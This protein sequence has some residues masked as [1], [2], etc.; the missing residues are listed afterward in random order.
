MAEQ[1]PLAGNTYHE[2]TCGAD[3]VTTTKLLDEVGRI[4]FAIGTKKDVTDLALSILV[5]GVHHIERHLG[6]HVRLARRERI[7]DLLRPQLL[8]LLRARHVNAV[9]VVETDLLLDP[10]LVFEVSLVRLQQSCDVAV[11]YVFAV[12]AEV[13]LGNDAKEWR[14]NFVGGLGRCATTRSIVRG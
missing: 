5:L 3:H 14:M 2:A 11:G 13:V 9:L 4:L 1:Y 7:C 10:P 8:G 12:S 6:A